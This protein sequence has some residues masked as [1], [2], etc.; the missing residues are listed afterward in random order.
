MKRHTKKLSEVARLRTGKLDS[1]AAV[2]GGEYPFFTC[3]QETY[4]IDNYAFDTEAVLLGGNNATG[5]FPLKYYCGKFNA[6]Q[7]TYIIETLNADVLSTRYL[8]HALRPALA[9]FQSASIGA[10]TQYLTKGILDN[11]PL[12]VPR[13]EVQREIE[14][15][16]SA[17]DDLIANNKRR[18]ELLEQSARLLF[19]EWFV[20]L[21]Y[22]GH[23][24]DRI[25]NGVPEGWERKLISELTSFISR[26]IAPKYNDDAEGLV[27][28]QK[29]IRNRLLDI[30]PARRQSK[31]PPDDKL[32]RTGDVLVNSTGE[33]TLGRVAQV[34]EECRN[35]T[36]D[37]HVTIVRPSKA[38]DAAFIGL[39]LTGMETYLASQGR[40]AT[41]Q[42]ELARASIAEIPLIVPPE[43]LRVELTE[44]VSPIFRQIANLKNQSRALAGA[45]DLLLPRLM[46]GRISV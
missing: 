42:K 28:N 18:I 24:H 32:V 34:I 6:Y 29:C 21:R 11:F 27:I 1:N 30:G 5:I 39:H 45:R 46:D 20:H 33:G 10:A 12:V 41:N 43:V 22:P 16:L 36:V 40:G 26:G 23:E 31:T 4:S 2:P 3:A 38:V 13:I 35:Y 14:R 25:V 19:K 7:R 8:Y 44:H 9:H 37:S 17:Y 15:N